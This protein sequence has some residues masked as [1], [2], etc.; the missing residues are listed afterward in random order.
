M[1]PLATVALLVIGLVVSLYLLF[2]G[3]F[4]RWL[5]QYRKDCPHCHRKK[6]AEVI[7]A[8]KGTK[9]ANG[10][11]VSEAYTIYQCNHCRKR[12]RTRVGSDDLEELTVKT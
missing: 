6:S 11:R 4:R 5:N 2:S 1:S 3:L 12:Y 8:F 10:E 7:D 9:F